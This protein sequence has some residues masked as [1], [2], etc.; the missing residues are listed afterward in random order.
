MRVLSGFESCGN[1]KNNFQMKLRKRNK[2]F[3]YRS[4]QAMYNED[5]NC[6]N[7]SLLKIILSCFLK[8]TLLYT[9]ISFVPSNANGGESFILDLS[10]SY[11]AR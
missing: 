1:F 9:R 8:A 3:V 11:L 5:V 10:M 6:Y 2:M 4:K 7:C